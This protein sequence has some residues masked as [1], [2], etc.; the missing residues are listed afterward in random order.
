MITKDNNLK[1]MELFFKFLYRTF[2][3]SKK[4]KEIIAG[5]N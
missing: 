5:I 2:P 3:I 4:V 1:V